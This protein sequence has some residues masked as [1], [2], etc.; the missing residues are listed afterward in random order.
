MNIVDANNLSF[1]YT[2]YNAEKK[3]EI[4]TKV[5]NNLNLKINP[6]EFVSIVGQNGSGK[7]T[8]A[9]LLNA[10]LLPTEGIL[11]VDGK[12]VFDKGEVW[13][14]RKS[15]GMVFQNPD[16]QII[17]ATVEGDVGFGPEN[18]GIHHDEIWK[19]VEKSLEAVHMTNY[20]YY[21]PN[22]LSGGQK[23]RLAIA[24]TLAMQSKCIIL[25]E[26]TA[27]ID[28]KG[29]DEVIKTIY[30]LNKSKGITIILITHHMEEVIHSDRL[31]VINQGNIVMH[32]TPQQIF[33]EID[34]LKKY[35]L[36]VPQTTLLANELKKE[37]LP[38]PEGII[39]DEEFIQA[40]LKLASS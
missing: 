6:G 36:E 19:R 22:M 16:N 31:I 24:G 32:G 3:E 30:N 34:L 15:A 27:M 5:L 37:G 10:L 33:T 26:P 14:I 35:G 8:L 39:E 12:N 9:K 40:I 25:D 18:L 28:P 21:S 20:R 4:L 2:K 38:I 7:S 1:S 23:Q 17:G 11:Y 29:R 13:N